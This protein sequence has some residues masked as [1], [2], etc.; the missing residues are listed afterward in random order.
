MTDID[1][2]YCVSGKVPSA[3]RTLIPLTAQKPYDVDT[4]SVPML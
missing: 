1:G 4:V 2:T 3:S